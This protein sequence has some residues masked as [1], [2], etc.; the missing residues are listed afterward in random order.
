MKIKAKRI[1]VVAAILVVGFLG[2]RAVAPGDNFFE[3]SKNLEIFA[4][5]YKELNIYYVDETQPGDLMK[6]GI[7]AMLLSLDPYTNYITESNIEDYRFMTTGQ[8]GGIGSLIRSVDGD[9]YISEPYEDSPAQKSGLRAGDKIIKID[10]ITISD[11][12]QDEISSLLKGQSG[13]DLK[14][15]YERFGTVS[16]VAITREEIKIPDV[17]YYGMLDDKVGYI[18]LNSFTQTASKEVREAFVEL[19]DDRGMEKLIFDLR[20][21][22][23]GL[24]REAIN[25]VNF[26]VPKGQEVVRTKGKI[27]EWDRTHIAINEPLDLEMPLVILVDQGSAS[28]SEIV[29]GSI[30]DLDRGVVIGNTTFGKGLVQQT[31][32]LQYNSKLKLTVAKYYIP[33]GRCIQKLDY[34]NKTEGGDVEEVPDSL[35]KKFATKSGRAV[36][37]G[38]GIEPDVKVENREIP[39]VVISLLTENLFFKYASDYANDRDTIADAAR[40]KLS[41]EDY[42]KFVKYLD[43]KNYSYTTDTE[44]EFEKLVTVAKDEKYYEITEEAFKQMEVAI[45]SKKN[46][47]LEIFREDIETI[48]ENEI[49]SRYY[50][51]KGRIENSLAEDPA[52]DSALTILANTEKYSQILK[53]Q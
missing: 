7:D 38:R 14:V 31:K 2:I 6:T 9:V 1:F 42:S 21:N 48:L 25:I 50:Y 43:G 34:S 28:A 32:D 36:M 20:G 33:S 4:T 8:Y 39:H 45:S 44:K 27:S 29:S 22:G 17:P 26:F 15:T 23:G 10:G 24:L 30:Q 12:D 46:N 52:I 40:F 37:D 41:D 51:Q 5:L 47:D 11:K 49:V 13:T 19:R 18:S 16:D 3:V 35:L 53:P